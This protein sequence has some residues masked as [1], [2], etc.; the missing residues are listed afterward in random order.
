LAYVKAG[1]AALK[2][3]KGV[4]RWFDCG[5]QEP[6]GQAPNCSSG[7]RAAVVRIEKAGKFSATEARRLLQFA[8]DLQR[9]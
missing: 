2:S 8:K 1:V 5:E 3:G 7:Q 4:I 6:R 9:L